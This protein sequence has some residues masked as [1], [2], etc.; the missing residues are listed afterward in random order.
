[1]TQLLVSTHHR[2]QRVQR[3]WPVSVEQNEKKSVVDEKQT[4]YRGHTCNA[5]RSNIKSDVEGDILLS[6]HKDTTQE[7]NI[8]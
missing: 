3:V 6:T 7:E 4:S 1:M 5:F 2:K 8:Q